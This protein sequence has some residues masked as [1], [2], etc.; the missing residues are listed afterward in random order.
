MDKE[1]EIRESIS[2]PWLR[3]SEN[4]R[5]VREREIEREREWKEL[6]TASYLFVVR[7]GDN[8]FACES[9]FICKKLAATPKN[10]ASTCFLS[11]CFVVVGN[12]LWRRFPLVF[13]I[14]YRVYDNGVWRICWRWW[15][16]WRK[17][18]KKLIVDGSLLDTMELYI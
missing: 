15:K 13:W 3:V 1:E 17:W 6:K 12:E 4:W 7:R 14:F 11:S 9:R 10:F 16:T 8:K 18:K 2:L 5:E